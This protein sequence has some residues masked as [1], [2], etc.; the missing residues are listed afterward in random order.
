[1]KLGAYL[2]GLA[3]GFPFQSTLISDDGIFC[4]FAVC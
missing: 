2:G 1:M 4:C 3:P